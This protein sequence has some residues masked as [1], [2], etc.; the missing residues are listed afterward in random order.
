ML[1]SENMINTSLMYIL[2][3]FLNILSLIR[4][5]KVNISFIFPV[6]K[7][8]Q[9]NTRAGTQLC[10]KYTVIECWSLR[11]NHSVNVTTYFQ[12]NWWAIYFQLVC[13]LLVQ[14][15]C[16]CVKLF[17]QNDFI[18]LCWHADLYLVCFVLSTMIIYVKLKFER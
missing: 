5:F 18:Y 11:L 8:A 15:Q 13:F 16:V 3:F 10:M 17:T 4:Y 12:N 14:F 2:D 6:L 9:R 7:N 1:A